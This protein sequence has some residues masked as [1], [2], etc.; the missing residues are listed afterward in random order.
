MVAPNISEAAPKTE[1]SRSMTYPQLEAF[2]I[3]EQGD[4]TAE[5]IKKVLDSHQDQ[6]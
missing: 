4:A 2:V 3:R 5:S 6:H 1:D